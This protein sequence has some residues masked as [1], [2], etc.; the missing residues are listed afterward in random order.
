[1][2]Q[3]AIGAKYPNI[4]MAWAAADGLKIDFQKAGLDNVQNMFFNGWKH[5]HYINSVFVFTP[6]GK[7]RMC[8]INDPG[9]FHDSTMSDYGIYHGMET[10]FNAAG[11]KVVVDSAFKIVD[12]EYVIRPSKIDP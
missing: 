12:M 5:G 11:G 8:L 1:M 9:K 3:D 2:C 10:V 4:G 7:I 6:D